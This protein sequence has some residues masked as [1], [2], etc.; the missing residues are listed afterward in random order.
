M[1]FIG[2]REFKIN[3][4]NG[5][6]TLRCFALEA[7]LVSDDSDDEDGQKKKAKEAE[8]N[9]KTDYTKVRMCRFC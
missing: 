6:P 2:C 9:Q 1:W 8:K 4:S 5:K 7:N 3:G